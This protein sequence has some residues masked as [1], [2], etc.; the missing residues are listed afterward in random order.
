MLALYPSAIHGDNSDR[1]HGSIGG[2]SDSQ[3]GGRQSTGTTRLQGADLRHYCGQ[4]GGPELG[5]SEADLGPILKRLAEAEANLGN[6]EL[7]I[8]R[9]TDAE[10]TR[11]LLAKAGPD[12]PVLAISAGIFRFEQLQ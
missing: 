10:Q 6:V 7:V 3:G 1:R 2:R 11:H 9:A 8:G 5:L 4:A 12:S